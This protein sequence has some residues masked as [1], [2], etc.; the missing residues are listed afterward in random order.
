MASAGPRPASLRR[1]LVLWLLVFT[2]VISLLVFAIGIVV[3]EKAEHAA[4]SSLLESELDAIEANAAIDPGHRWQDSETLHL[5]RLDG[6]GAL[7]AALAGLDDGLSDNLLVEGR[8]SVAQVRATAQGRMA[9]VLDV[10]DFEQTEVYA[11]RMA[12]LGGLALIVVTTLAA[13]L[14]VGRLVRPL[15]VLAGD[16]DRLHPGDPTQRIEVARGGSSEL[17]VIADALNDYLLRNAQF[18]K[19]ERVFI[20]TASHELRTPLAVIAG[21]AELALDQPGLPPRAARQMQRVLHTTRAVE[22][23]VQLLLVLARDP[24][25]LAAMSELIALDGLLARIVEDHHHLLGD[26]HLRI[27]YGIV[28]P[29]TILAPPAVVQAAIGNLLRNA[30][31]NSDRGVI[32]VSLS[33]EAVVCIDDPGHG[34]SPE[35]ISAIHAR[36]A[37]RE[38]GEAPDGIGLDLVGRLCEHLGWRLGFAPH[39]PQGTRVILGLGASLDPQ[40]PDR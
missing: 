34:M 33:G 40:A 23:L 2:A 31:E 3:H 7:P 6:G 25:R 12:L 18:V 8:R 39:P 37:R 15:A 26:K 21:A 19:R 16:I 9:L 32:R 11:E 17:Y 27:E 20:T 38:R 14:G 35:E 5:Y 4:W 24:A 10:E 29:C 22:Q 1:R 30:I 36:R 13:W 28:S